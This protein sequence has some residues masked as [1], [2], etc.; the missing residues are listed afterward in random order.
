MPDSIPC[1][2]AINDAYVQ[3][4]SVVIVSAASNSKSRLAFHI[5]HSSLSPESKKQI[6]SLKTLR[7]FD[8]EY[9]RVDEKATGGIQ[10][11]DE[12]ISIETCYRLLI[13]TL[14][15][16][17]D[18]AIYL[19]ADLVVRHDLSEL[20][21]MDIEGTCAGVVEDMVFDS[22]FENY[23]AIFPT[24][25]YFNAGVLL[26]NLKKIRREIPFA[27]F[28]EIERR[29]RAALRH[30]DQDLLNI[31]FGGNVTYLPLKWNVTLLFFNPARRFPK[32]LGFT[33]AEVV[34]A[35]ENPA[36]AHFIGSHKP[37]L[38][39][40]GFMASPYAPEYFKYLDKITK[41]NSYAEAVKKFPRARDFL[42]YWRR[43]P[44]FF[45]RPKTYALLK[46]KRKFS[47]GNA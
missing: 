40:C 20:W 39:P 23:D 24:R 6:E 38:V 45:L 26:L 12:H 34:A 35:R 10:I 11:K 7:D 46:A 19:D 30:Q 33:K 16:E 27:R 18:K 37:W 8:L 29:H 13:P 14:R 4:A 25:R 9:I 3:H 41:G 47:I 43:H 32:T 1:F 21:A 36:I 2:L 5:L 42:V 28:M 22:K 15:P 31:A 44:F 17:L